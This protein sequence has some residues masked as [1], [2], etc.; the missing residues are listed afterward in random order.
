MGNILFGERKE[1]KEN[2]YKWETIFDGK[3]SSSE[4]RPCSLLG[5]K[6]I[7]CLPGDAS[8]A[9]KDAN[10]VCGPVER[11]L[12]KAGISQKDIPHI[13]GVAYIGDPAVHRYKILD[14]LKQ[15]HMTARPYKDDKYYQTL[16]DK[17]IMPLLIDEKGQPR[18]IQ[19]IEKNLQNLI[20]VSH[21]HGSMLAHQIEQSIAE[22]IGEFYPEKQKEIMKNLHMI[23]FASRRPVGHA[24]ASHLD[25]ISQNDEM[26][27]DDAVLEHDNVLQ[28]IHRSS[29]N[30]SSVL[31]SHSPEETALILKALTKTNNLE[32]HWNDYPNTDRDHRFVLSIFAEEGE[33]ALKDNKEFDFHV[34]QE[35]ENAVHVVQQLL[36]HFV[37]NPEDNRNLEDVLRQIDP[38]FTSENLARGAKF[39]AQEKEDENYRRGLLSLL[40]DPKFHFK[41]TK[42]SYTKKT[43]KILRR[44]STKEI[45]KSSNGSYR[46][47]LLERNLEGQ[48]LFQELINQYKKTGDSQPLINYMD[49]V[50]VRNDISQQEQDDLALLAVQNHDWLLIKKVK[51]ISFP[52]FLKIIKVIQP[53]DLYHLSP[54]IVPMVKVLAKD[55]DSMRQFLQKVQDIKNQKHKRQ[56]SSVVSE[57][58]PGSELKELLKELSIKEKKSLKSLLAEKRQKE[59]DRYL[60][61][62]RERDQ[63]GHHLTIKEM[64][65]AHSYRLSPQEYL[66]FKSLKKK[67][68]T[69]NFGVYANNIIR[70]RKDK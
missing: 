10:A 17:Y 42:R 15:S 70:N 12:L 69:L 49:A 65:T 58:F 34:V 24:Y 37:E 50:R 59:A 28:Q 66:A 53:E 45:R 26:Y 68:P 16:L 61:L 32:E 2:N 1:T 18:S 33:Q 57:Y 44:H 40:S 48:F 43:Q 3:K 19:D 38:N 20:F 55:P 41:G 51:L 6:S 5:Q 30:D 56:I 64:S 8:H 46:P 60:S 47:L 7:I 63:H 29:M 9:E 35:N 21:C 39:L 14:D 54:L 23:H 11:M 67:D 31:L 13:Y 22:K 52:Q 25:I 4:I 27:A 36:K 62:Q